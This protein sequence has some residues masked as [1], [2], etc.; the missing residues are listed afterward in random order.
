MG[1]RKCLESSGVVV[2]TGRAIGEGMTNTTT[3][4][5]TEITS[6]L[7]SE[8]VDPTDFWAEM[9]GGDRREMPAAEL[10]EWIEMYREQIADLT[11]DGEE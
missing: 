7:Q 6:R 10:A 1:A 5:L 4:G 9:M 3:L 2:G 8:G 11:D